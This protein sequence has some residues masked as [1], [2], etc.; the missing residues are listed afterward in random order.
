MKNNI[1][2]HLV[3]FA[4]FLVAFTACTDEMPSG[5][6]NTSNININTNQLLID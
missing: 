6:M 3:L 5:N 2:L 4:L 1:P